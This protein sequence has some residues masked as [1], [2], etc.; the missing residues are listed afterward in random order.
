MEA[1]YLTRYES[2]MDM[3]ICKKFCRSVFSCVALKLL[4][5]FS[6]SVVESD[7]VVRGLWWVLMREG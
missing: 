1:P 4:D 2:S 5:E 7:R 6:S 3:I